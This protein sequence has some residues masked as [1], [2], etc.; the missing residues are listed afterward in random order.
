MNSTLASKRGE[1]LRT[2]ADAYASRRKLEGLRSDIERAEQEASSA[3]KARQAFLSGLNHELRTPLNHIIGFA[4]LIKQADEYGFDD[5]KKEEYLD[6]ILG[7]AGT[8]LDQINAILVSAGYGEPTPAPDSASSLV[9]VLRRVIQENTATLFV[10]KVDIADDLPPSTLASRDLYKVLQMV[11]SVLTAKTRERRTL[12]VKAE[13]PMAGDRQVVL[14][15]SVL[16][17]HDG[18]SESALNSARTEL[19]NHGGRL[20]VES[21]PGTFQIAVGLP[22]QEQRQVA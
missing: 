20:E 11:F 14:V 7:A 2:F 4:E 17:A 12:G 6:L 10:G 5:D 22:I 1:A 8:L 13:A 16:S 9:T 3:E 15:L 18:L 19:I 21:G